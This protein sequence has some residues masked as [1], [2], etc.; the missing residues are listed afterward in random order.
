MWSR[1]EQIGDL[2]FHWLESGTGPGLVLLHGF[3]ES[4]WSWQH[5]IEPLARAGFKV[6]ALDLRGYGESEARA[7]YD[8]ASLSADVA[9]V[10]ES[11]FG[12]AVGLVGH[13]WGGGIAWHL[14]AHRPDL[15]R[16]LCIL[17]APHPG[18]YQRAIRSCP[19]QMWASWYMYFFALPWIPELVLTR[20]DGRWIREFVRHHCLDSDP[21]DDETLDRHLRPLLD[22]SGLSAA[23]AY[24]R[25]AVRRGLLH[26]REFQELPSILMPT[27]ILWG[28][29]DPSMVFD[30]LVPATLET[31][32]HAELEVFDAGHY[33]QTEKPD[34]VTPRLLDFFAPLLET[35]K[36]MSL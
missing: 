1:R 12:E 33:L 35:S 2:A 22:G 24:Y 19:R 34:Q 28:R 9:N 21:F 5:Q 26:P 31:V 16:R 20:Q 29:H 14:A 30:V 11:V 36:G 7:P 15:V 32:P 4:A 17:N 8:L 18:P 6:I 13:D 27:R 3:P 25:T 10:I 23:L